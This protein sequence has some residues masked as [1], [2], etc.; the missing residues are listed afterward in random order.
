MALSEADLV[1]Q[2]W[3]NL[4]AAVAAVTVFG[5][6]LGEMFPLLSLIME[7]DGLSTATIGYNT[8]MQPVGILLA[9]FVV[10]PAVRRYGAKPV[11]LSA[12]AIAALIVLVYPLTPIFWAWFVLRAVQG[13]AVATLFTVSE[14]WVIQY[15][16]GAYRAR[17]VAIYSSVLAISFGLG[18][19]LIAAIGIEGYFPFAIGAA[20]L[21][22]AAIPIFHVRENLASEQGHEP[23]W[24][25]TFFPKAP[26][27]L[28]AVGVF[29][30][31]DAA[32][33]G[34]LPVYGI[35][36]GL[37]QDTAALMLSVLVIGNIVLQFPIG[38]LGDHFRKR[39]VM[40]GCGAV[41]A[42]GIAFLPVSVGTPW[43]WVILLVVGAS[44][45][46]IYTIALA[47]LGERFSG[48]DLVA[49][50]AAMS[51]MWGGGAL[52]GSLMTG[53]VMAGIGTDAFAYAQSIVFGIFLVL[54]FLRERSK[55]RRQAA[56]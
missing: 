30:V 17:I 19:T 28:V 40:A 20:V 5:F 25:L 24:F 31:F 29:A 9:G 37:E 12:T 52:M 2:R 11:V 46:G 18:P 43:M 42:F 4:F 22:A 36:R 33:L 8:A 35:K 27:L 47:E 16:D 6:A 44:S 7:R 55:R 56:A 39:A 32:C 15:A 51:T 49:G 34:F 26:V 54:L 3:L 10:P 53:W 13:L 14:A 38:W 41:T 45:A 48:T 21:L 50:T 23:S 1:R